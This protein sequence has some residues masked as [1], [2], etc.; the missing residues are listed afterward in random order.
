MSRYISNSIRT[1]VAKNAQFH[2][3]YCLL[4][5]RYAILPFHIEHI[6]SLKHGGTSDIENLAFSCPEC[7]NHKGSDIATFI[8]IDSSNLVRFFNPRKDKWVDHFEIEST[9]VINAKTSIGK[10][11]IKILNVNQATS[12]EIRKILLK[13]NLL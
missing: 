7:N 1:F 13:K 10:A 9:G 8:G 11:T 12:V 3:E 4:L 6:I 5:E 2:C